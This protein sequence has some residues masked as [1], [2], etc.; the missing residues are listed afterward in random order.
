[1]WKQKIFCLSN[2]L[3]TEKETVGSPNNLHF[4]KKS[5]K[6]KFHR[7]LNLKEKCYATSVGKEITAWTR[8]LS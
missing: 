2:R 1:M 3:E 4:L 7:Y 5:T 8:M 6:P